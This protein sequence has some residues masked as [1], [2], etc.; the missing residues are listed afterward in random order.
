M[1]EVT[2]TLDEELAALDPET[3]AT[4]AANGFEASWLKQRIAAS[5]EA[6][7][8]ARADRNRL[9]GPA[10]PPAPG[11]IPLAPAPGTPEHARLSALGLPPLA[12][13]ELAF[14]V[15]A[16]GMATRMGG[17]VK[18]LVEALPPGP[19]AAGRTFLDLRLEE[20]AHLSR[21][22]GAELPLWIRTSDAT[23]GPIRA[24]LAAAGNP[25]AVRTFRQGM[26]LRLTE[27]GHLFKDAA[28][29][30]G[31]HATG[32][33]DLVDAMIRGGLLP[34]AKIRT[35]LVTNLD[36]LGATV[37]PALLGLFLESGKKVQFEVVAKSNDKG[38]IPVY[39]AGAASAGGADTL[40]VVEEFRLPAGFDATT[41]PV[42]NTNTFLADASAL[43]HAK[44]AWSY[45]EVEKKVDGRTAI[46]FERL[47]QD[48]TRELPTGYV[49]V[50]R[51]GPGS[52]F[53]P[54]KD[55]AELEARRPA[56]ESALRSRGIL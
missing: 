32:H 42:F 38:G 39:A 1:N 44:V 45:S 21:T 9:P 28:G 5:R 52:R 20:R 19:G 51:E 29:K 14:V 35:V 37:D 33:G 46:Q 36:N 48:I 43:A 7:G 17:V 56:I 3:R 50:P 16:G 22:F 25:P 40:Q 4:L 31:L 11:D 49:E 12:R 34:D 8:T 27:D 55:P 30:P 23:D 54:V 18:A 13:G 47:I 53:L 2:S 10:R 15:M 41:V 24:A 26:S 6:S